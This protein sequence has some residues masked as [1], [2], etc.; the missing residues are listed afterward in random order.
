MSSN[1][2][3]ENIGN[4]KIKNNVVLIKEKSKLLADKL[5]GTAQNIMSD[6]RS[7]R[8]ISNHDLITDQKVLNRLQNGIF[9]AG[10]LS[11]DQ[12]SK[13]FLMKKIQVIEESD[14]KNSPPKAKNSYMQ[15]AENFQVIKQS[16]YR[17]ITQTK[18]LNDEINRQNLIGFCNKP[19]DSQ[20][21]L[22]TVLL[23]SNDTNQIDK[24][25]HYLLS[26]FDRL[27]LRFEIARTM[28][29]IASKHS[30]KMLVVVTRQNFSD[31]VK[32]IKDRPFPNICIALIDNSADCEKSYYMDETDIRNIHFNSLTYDSIPE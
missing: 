16:M 32:Y 23:Y 20:T 31:I 9:G 14:V 7:S 21:T 13:D 4:N 3:K 28:E 8:H 25:F 26:E 17:S 19:V 27:G 2:M 22:D 24:R 11:K 5:R 15:F 29:V 12:T 18:K 6:R 10:L 30:N 1:L